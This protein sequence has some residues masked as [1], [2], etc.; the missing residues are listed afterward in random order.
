MG[1]TS[2]HVCPVQISVGL[3]NPIRR[4]LQN[5]GKILEPYI[6]KG[7]TV[8]DAGCGP[9]FFSTEMAR[10]VGRSGRVIAADLQ[11]GMLLKVKSKVYGTELE[12]RIVLHKCGEDKIGISEF[13]DFVLVFYMLHEVASQENFLGEIGSILKPG[14][15]ILIVEPLFHFSRSAFETMIAKA[16]NIGLKVVNKPKMVFSRAAVLKK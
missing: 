3:D 6:E 7:M 4:W 10:L 9:G 5:P 11:E 14:G 13:V 2:R 16:Q 8:L 12:N 15:Q 1:K